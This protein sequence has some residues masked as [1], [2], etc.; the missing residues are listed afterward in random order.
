MRF[1]VVTLPSV[2]DILTDLWLNA[3]DQHAVTDAANWIERQLRNDALS[4]VT[5]I[6]DAYF[7]AVRVRQPRLENGGVFQISLSGFRQP[8]ELDLPET[9]ALQRGIAQ[10]IA[11]YRI[12]IEARHTAPD[13]A[14]VRINQRRDGAVAEN[15][16]IE[17][18]RRSAHARAS[19][20][21]ER[22]N[23]LSNLRKAAGLAMRTRAFVGD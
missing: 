3:P 17:G 13:D 7:I 21:G 15:R 9:V 10:Q 19:M 5:A 2:D 1:T 11:E 8:E 14:R 6:D 22:T 20:T 12:A 16:E 4:K 18:W 23:S